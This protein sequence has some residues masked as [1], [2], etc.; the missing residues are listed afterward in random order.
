MRL[1]CGSLVDMIYALL[2]NT[3]HCRR[4]PE[5]ALNNKEMKKNK[6]SVDPA[7]AKE[8]LRKQQE[9]F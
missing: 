7:L 8:W 6:W 2:I 1:D 5:E 4:C 3:R 9:K